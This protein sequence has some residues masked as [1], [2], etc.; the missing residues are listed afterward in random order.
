[1]FE[2]TGVSKRYGDLTALARTDLIFES[3]RTTVLIGP[4]GSGKSTV[5]R[6][7][8]RLIPPDTGIVR[9]AGQ[10]LTDDNAGLLR[11][12]MGFVVQ[13]GGLFPHLSA[14][15]N[16][17]LMAR[18]L[19]WRK[20]RISARI[21]ELAELTHF[22]IDALTRFPAQLSG[23]QRQRVSLMRALMLDPDVLLMD[24]PLGALDPM[25]RF[26]LQ[27]ELKS[28]FR[29]LNK[30][31]VIVT[32]DL[33]EAGFFADTILLMRDGQIVQQGML[34]QLLQ[35]PA[36]EFVQKFIRAQRGSILPLDR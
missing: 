1:M 34:A 28:I 30:T 27:D 26:E 14:Q 36:N 18:Y 33:S 9:F 15:D 6:L 22:P 5:L 10:I 24:E 31:V 19:G 2:L 21:S 23:G 7:L 17:A 3:G 32:H 25:I 20:A 8:V 35:A 16:M 13:E 4:S 12:R 29:L 11:R